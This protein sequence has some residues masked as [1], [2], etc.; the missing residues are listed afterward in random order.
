MRGEEALHQRSHQLRVNIGEG[1]AQIILLARPEH[2]AGE[3]Q[4]IVF[5]RQS[6]G[7]GL[8]GLAAER[9]PDIGEIGTAAQQLV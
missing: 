7:D 8:R 5:L 9:M 6:H 3:A 1:E 4:D 2:G